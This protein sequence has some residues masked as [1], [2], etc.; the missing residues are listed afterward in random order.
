MDLNI[1][2]QL[3]FKK[4]SHIGIRC[5][6][7]GEY[8][9][10][11]EETIKLLTPPL[12]NFL[13]IYVRLHFLQIHQPEHIVTDLAEANIKSNHLLLGQTLKIFAKM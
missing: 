6:V 11:S 10:S 5:S 12:S 13:Y 4:L 7:K 8:S 9:H 2:L 3:T 1:I